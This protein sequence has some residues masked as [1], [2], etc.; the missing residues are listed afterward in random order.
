M[1]DP[2]WLREPHPVGLY[3]VGDQALRG[4]PETPRQFKALFRYSIAGI[5]ITFESNV[6]YKDTDP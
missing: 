6:V 4:L 1:S 3:T 2:Y 5:P